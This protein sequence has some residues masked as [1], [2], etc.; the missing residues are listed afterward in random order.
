MRYDF[1]LLF[2]VLTALTGAI[3]LLD[4][5]LFARARRRK[6]AEE[7]AALGQIMDAVVASDTPDAISETGQ[8]STVK[9]EKWH[10]F[11]S[12]KQRARIIV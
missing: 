9:G 8:T 7:H 11:S 12:G 6:V 5:L 10:E 3:W 1:A 2:T 4:S